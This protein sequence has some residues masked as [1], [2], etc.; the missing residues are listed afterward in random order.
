M[1]IR[2]TIASDL[3]A[4]MQIYADAR[5]MMVES[6]NHNQWTGGHPAQAIIENDIA[7]GKS[8][9]CTDGETVLAVFYLDIA[10]DP[11]YAKI[12]GAWQRPDA[13]YG[14]VHRIARARGAKGAGAF[15]LE[16]CFGQIPNIRIDTHRDNAPMIKLLGRLGYKY[17]GTIWLENGDERLA[18]QKVGAG[19]R[20][21]EMSAFFNSRAESY[22]E[23]HVGHIDG[24]IESKNV[25]ASFL[26]AHTKSIIDF[27]I[28]TGLELKGIF[29]RFPN[30]KITGLD[31]AENMLDLLKKTYPDKRINLYCESYLDYDFGDNLYD[32]AVSVMTLHHYTHEVKTNLYRKIY[33]CVKQ[34]GVYVECDYMLSAHEH[35]NPQEVEDFHFSEYQRLKDEQGL[36]DSM[37][38]HYD[39][40]C[41]V[42]NQ[43]TMLLEA[44][45]SK[46]SEVW[47]KKDTVVLVAEK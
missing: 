9:V 41:T 37:K 42:D 45:F 47:R 23:V 34:N 7:E 8:Y 10:P 38:Y 15:C 25:I 43:I 35:E 39:T 21:E 44:G 19:N 17:C 12:D 33:Q 27:G 28:G 22:N 4:V 36:T 11:T 18:F 6:G 29:D 32:A 13:E 1:Q 2:K 40:P 16:W 31:I 20:L 26:P 14:V 30:A 24:G 5:Q 46:V 3:P